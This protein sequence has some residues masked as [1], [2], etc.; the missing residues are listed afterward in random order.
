VVKNLQEHIGHHFFLQLRVENKPLNASELYGSGVEAGAGGELCRPRSDDGC[1][2]DVRPSGNKGD[3]PRTDDPAG[4]ARPP[5]AAA[6]VDRGVA[7]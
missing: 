4:G 7:A 1:G 6:R 5:R 3:V 2:D